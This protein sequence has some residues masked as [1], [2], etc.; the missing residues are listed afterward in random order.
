MTASNSHQKPSKRFLISGSSGLIGWNLCTFLRA[1]GHEVYLLVRR[2]P[3]N[4]YE[5]WWDIQEKKIEQEKLEGLDIIVHL[6]GE[7]ID[8]RWTPE[9]KERILKSRVQGTSLLVDTLIQLAAPPKVLISASAVGIYGNHPDEVATE[10]TPVAADF[11]GDVC[12]QWEQASQKAREKGIRVVNPRFGVVLSKDGGALQRMLPVF[13]MGFGGRIGSG[14]QWM[15]WISL[16]DVLAL[17]LEISMNEAYEG[18][19]NAVSPNPLQNKGF[20]SILGKI[21]QRPTFLPAPDFGVKLLFGE[22]GQTLVLEGRKVLPKRA[23]ELG[24]EF[25]FPDLEHFLRAELSGKQKRRKK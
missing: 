19:I 13:K 1:K 25:Q 5:V 6:A 16:P 11:L 20:T 14:M 3:T 7:S 17:I 21:L 2:S 15:S 8:G 18:A 22:M 9:K 24:F 23:L 10:E 4:P 12:Q